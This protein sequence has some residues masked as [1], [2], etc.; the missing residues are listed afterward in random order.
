MPFGKY[1][2]F[3]ECVQDQMSKGYT[4]YEAGGICGLIEKRHKEKA[5]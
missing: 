4:R 5:K 2:N 3:E 1:K